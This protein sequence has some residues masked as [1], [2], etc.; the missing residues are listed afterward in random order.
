MDF[1]KKKYLVVVAILVIIGIGIFLRS[2]NFSDW[3]HFELDQARDANFVSKG[4]QEGV[5]NLPVLGPKAAGTYLRLGPAFY[6]LEY[7][8]A[9]FFGDTPPGHAMSVLIFSIASLP[10]FYFFC[11]RYFSR[12]ISIYL[13]AIFSLSVFLI[14]YS[15]FS[16]N[17]NPLPF[18]VLLSFYSLIRAVSD[19]EK[20]K[21]VW[22]ILFFL[23]ATISTQLHFLALILIPVVSIVFLIIKRPHI[24]LWAWIAGVVVFFI[25][26]SPV[27]I[28]DVKTGGENFKEFK[29]TILEQGDK[30]HSWPAKFVR[31]I[32]NNSLAYYLIVTGD[33]RAEL[34][35]IVVLNLDVIKNSC[36][37]DCRK[38][39]VQGIAA[40]LLFVVGSLLLL[41]NLIKKKDKEK[42][43][44]LQL[45]FIWLAVSFILFLPIAFQM[46]PRFYLLVAPLSIIYVGFI[47][48]IIKPQKNKKRM[49]IVLAILAVIIGSNLYYAYSRFNELS[50]AKDEASN[51]PV[52]DKI[53]RERVRVTLEQQ[54]E[55]ADY[56][57]SFH[58]KNSYPIYIDSEDYFKRSLTYLVKIRGI[59][60]DGLRKSKIYEEGNYFVVYA[61]LFS[62]T[63]EKVA[64]YE[65]YY[66]VVEEK[67]FGTLTLF[68]L[69]PKPENI[70]D[71][72]Q[73]FTIV[74]KKPASRAPDRYTWKELFAKDKEKK[75]EDIIGD[76]DD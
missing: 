73:D 60:F 69:M 23:G 15:R 26:Y 7:L 71:Q 44:F 66:Y 68:H 46:F 61:T 10:L 29:R 32:R 55:I 33:E 70:T 3:M 17:P 24:R 1:I 42:K 75:A 65:E 27:I 16:W 41:W 14:I 25:L 49:Y 28:N 31:N 35:E 64:E 12:N 43:N 47:F 30:E 8:S 4:A 22:L 37:D 48:E 51:I 40:V 9:K 36:D 21:E 72:K 57:E 19:D 74:E 67:K 63:D 62:K 18:F 59:D 76:E 53:L 34:P 52:K 50:R 6:Y 2:Y 58:K 5:E 56:M 11:R 20:R 38:H 39:A 13:L 45:L 54:N